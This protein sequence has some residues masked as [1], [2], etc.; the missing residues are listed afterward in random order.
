VGV[1]ADVRI[2]R[3]AGAAL[4]LAGAGAGLLATGAVLH[5]PP[6]CP[7]RAAAGV[8]CAS[9][10]LTRAVAAALRGDFGAAVALNPGAPLVL[11]LAGAGA[12][13][14]VAEAATGR[15]L[16]APAWRGARAVVVAA[17][18]AAAAEVC[19]LRGLC[20]GPDLCGP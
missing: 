11:L 8:P 16:L 15:A 7:L 13:L 1:V 6:L 18:V 20:G 19:V 17:L 5:L 12:A 9:C 10:G 3:R 14:L 4:L 2:R